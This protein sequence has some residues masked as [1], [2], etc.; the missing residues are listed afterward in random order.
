M[1]GHAG[2]I[3][4]ICSHP[5]RS[6][7]D[8]TVLSGL[9]S[10]SAIARQYGVSRQAIMRHR[11][12]HIVA[13]LKEAAAR[14]READDYDRGASLLDRMHELGAEAQ[15]ALNV[16]KGQKDTRLILAAIGTASKLL[17]LQGRLQGEIGGGDTTINVTMND[18]R[19]LQVGIVAALA[20]FPDAKR[21]VLAA[22]GGPALDADA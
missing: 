3:C 18:F 16:A 7:I 15:A 11:D 20:P 21:A 5:R 19:T 6:E 8:R 22:L 2:G 10:V 4:S 12:A 14:R 9:S 1:P 13:D 17:E